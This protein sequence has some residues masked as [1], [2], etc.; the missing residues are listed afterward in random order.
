MDLCSEYTL[1]FCKDLLTVLVVFFLRDLVV[2]S[3]TARLRGSTQK[4]AGTGWLGIVLIQ[5]VLL[6]IQ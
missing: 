5:H 1:D 2:S 6:G 4:F 3:D